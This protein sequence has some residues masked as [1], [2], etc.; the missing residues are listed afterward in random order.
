M[1]YKKGRHAGR[2]IETDRVKEERKRKQGLEVSSRVKF[3][4]EIALKVVK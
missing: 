2:Q 3:C 1:R 4:I